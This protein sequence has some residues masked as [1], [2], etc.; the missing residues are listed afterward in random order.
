M[1]LY[2]VITDVP[3]PILTALVFLAAR[4]GV[5]PFVFAVKPRLTDF[6]G[7]AI[8]ISPLFLNFDLAQLD[9]NC[10]RSHAKRI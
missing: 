6:F 8:S 3:G 1:V 7:V 5:L 2:A 4:F 9:F 10:C